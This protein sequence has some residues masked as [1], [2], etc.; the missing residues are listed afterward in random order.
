MAGYEATR[1]GAEKLRSLAMSLRNSSDELLSSSNA[2][3]NTISGLNDLGDFAPKIESVIETIV[4][5]QN[6]SQND[7]SFLCGRLNELAN[8][9]DS[10]IASF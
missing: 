4:S 8:Q 10:R 5:T 6:R 2:L 1:K 7:I 3:R 9:V